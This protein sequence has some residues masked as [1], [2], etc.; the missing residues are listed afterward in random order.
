MSKPSSKDI[1][2]SYDRFSDPK[3]SQGDSES[4]QQR[5]FAA[6]CER[7]QLRPAK[8]HFIDRGYS[9][10]HDRHYKKGD[11]GRL[12]ELGRGGAFQPKPG[13]SGYVLVVE[14]WDR[15]GRL[16][17]DKQ[18]E[19]ISELLRTG[20]KIGVCRLDDIFSEED[21]G[22]HKFTTLSVFVQLA[23]QESLQKS[24]RIAANW[25]QRKLKA[26]EEGEL[27]TT[28][29][30]AWLEYVKGTVRVIPERKA[31]VR[32]IFELA[33]AGYSQS[34]IVQTFTREGV[35]AFGEKKVNTGRK[36]S[37]FSGY[38]TRPYVHTILKDRRVIGEYQPTKWPGRK[39]D[40]PPIKDYFPAVVSE[41]EFLLARA[42]LEKRVIIM[43]DENG[44]PV[45]RGTRQRKHI[46]L[47]AG[48]LHNATDGEGWFCHNKGTVKKPDLILINASGIGGHTKCITFPL[49]IFERA[50]LGLMKE[51]SAKD[52]APSVDGLTP[53]D[54]MSAKLQDLGEH[55][56]ALADD[57]RKGYSSALT[58]VLR[59]KEAEHAKIKDELDSLRA[60]MINPVADDWKHFPNLVD[61][62]EKAENKED[63]RLRVRAL[64]RR[65]V[66]SIY[67]LIV[68][69]RS[70][71]LV[72][73]QVFFYNGICRSYLILHQTAAYARKGG[74]D[75]CSLSDA[76]ALGPRDLRKPED[77]RK[78]EAFLSAVNVETLAEAMKQLRLKKPRAKS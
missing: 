22:T 7:H 39:P 70:Y 1:G 73:A 75:A 46:N 5:A 51:V 49:P 37:Q 68:R 24:E 78:L 62:I 54:V 19:R 71:R 25:Q 64:L 72:A 48:L 53:V 77:V 18:M 40:G 76:V 57:L 20:L 58:T 50:V 61:A 30:P 11:F 36:R 28:R 47:F 55:I 14:A 41:E 32:R 21:F 65:A 42:A 15:L 2:I 44:R 38:W 52:L 6:F 60:E 4:R 31:I 34:K 45:R 43:K 10:F 29:L 27:T 59:E 8:D 67:L 74:W 17:P 35:P 56:S 69:R 66:E 16:R 33:I 9:G 13:V 26:R 3:Q 63:A 23:Y 12:L